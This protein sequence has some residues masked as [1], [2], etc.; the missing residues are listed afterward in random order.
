MELSKKQERLEYLK[1]LSPENQLKWL[2]ENM[3]SKR[4]RISLNHSKKN[5]NEILSAILIELFDVMH[6]DDLNL[7]TNPIKI[8]DQAKKIYKSA[9]MI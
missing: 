4:K 1:T 7:I 2:Q 9:R 8:L 5:S 6:D 3:P